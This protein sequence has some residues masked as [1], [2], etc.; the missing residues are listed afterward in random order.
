MGTRYIRDSEIQADVIVSEPLTTFDVEHVHSERTIGNTLAINLRQSPGLELSW[1]TL[2]NESTYTT[3]TVDASFAAAGNHT[4]YLESFDENSENEIAPATLKLD[5]V[6]IVV[7]GWAPSFDSELSHQKIEM[8]TATSW[9]LPIVTENV[10]SDTIYHLDANFLLGKVIVDFK[11]G[12]VTYDGTDL[13]FCLTSDL[14][15]RIGLENDYGA[16]WYT[17]SLTI[18]ATA[19]E[20]CTTDEES[21]VE[22]VAG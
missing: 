17:Q 3:V 1:V 19:G 13:G 16:N 2:S 15:I 6:T 10:N 7:E 14:E 20:K 8:G 11:N 4:L 21:L 18:V 22:S 12:E 5:T 9:L